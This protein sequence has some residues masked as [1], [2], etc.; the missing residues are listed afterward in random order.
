MLRPYNRGEVTGFD[1]HTERDN[2]PFY[3]QTVTLV[4]SWLA[5]GG[6]ACFAI[7]FTA[8][9]GHL[10]PSRAVVVALAVALTFSGYVIGTFAAFISRSLLFTLDAVLLPLLTS[11]VVGLFITVANHASQ[12]DLDVPS[13]AY[14]LVP[15]I[16]S[17]IATIITG[18]FAFIVSRKIRG[19]KKSDQRRRQHVQRWDRGQSVSYGDATSTSE[20]LPMDAMPPAVPL[21]SYG[22][23]EDEAQR[24]QLL[25]L[26]LNREPADSP[27][28][29]RPPSTYR[30]NLPGE[31]NDLTQLLPGPRTRA[32]SLPSSPNKFNVLNN[33]KFLRNK[34]PPVDNSTNPRE[35]RREEIERGSISYAPMPSPGSGGDW[36]RTPGISPGL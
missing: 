27:L 11:S 9:D 1:L 8:Q 15:L 24:R 29:N 22:I 2:L 23:P 25:R 20:L 21:D 10:K 32:G 26:L 5:L 35:R 30:I 4:A 34:S 18:L 3:Y 17:G 33:L 6:Y 16:T 28:H 14:V 12:K 7:A 36:P 31:D 19:I 13:E